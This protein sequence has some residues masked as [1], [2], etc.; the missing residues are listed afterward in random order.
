M[1]CEAASG[2]HNQGSYVRC[3]RQNEWPRFIFKSQTNT[4]EEVCCEMSSWLNKQMFMWNSWVLTGF[5]SLILPPGYMHLTCIYVL[6]TY[7]FR[8]R[9]GHHR[10][11]SLSMLWVKS[12]SYKP[13]IVRYIP[14]LWGSLLSLCVS[15]VLTGLSSNAANLSPFHHSLHCLPPSLLP[16]LLFPLSLLSLSPDSLSLFFF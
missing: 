16:P 3:D 4:S 6:G 8:H 11:H 15:S 10:G 2:M 7:F 12:D 9:D 14:Q 5:S 13:T 1:C